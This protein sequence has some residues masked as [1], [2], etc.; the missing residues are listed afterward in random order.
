MNRTRWAALVLA[1]LAAGCADPEPEPAAVDATAEAHQAVEDLL[2]ARIDRD[3]DR[4]YDLTADHARPNSRSNWTDWQDGTPHKC[5]GDAPNGAVIDLETL[6][7]DGD[8]LVVEAA[9]WEQSTQARMCWWE[10][11]RVDGG[12]KVGDY[13]PRNPEGQP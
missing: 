13:L 1:L 10:T 3:W 2:R 7:G 6:S 9:V 12:W 5:V 4:V 8:R 11:V